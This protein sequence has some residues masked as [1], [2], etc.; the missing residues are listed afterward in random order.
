[1]SVLKA[2]DVKIDRPEA[3]RH[4]SFTDYQ[5][6]SLKMDFQEIRAVIK[7]TFLS[8]ETTFYSHSRITLL[9]KCAILS[10]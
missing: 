5:K 3:K 10:I 2:R 9:V 6:A 7:A 8:F 1:M 4:H